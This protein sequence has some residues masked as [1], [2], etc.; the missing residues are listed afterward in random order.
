[1]AR[2]KLILKIVVSLLI[3]QS[4]V[5]LPVIAFAWGTK[6]VGTASMEFLRIGV[7]ARPAAM[8]EAFSAVGDDGNSIF[9]NPAGLGR[10]RSQELSGMHLKWFESFNY[11]TLSYVYPMSH[12]ALGGGL[13]YL[14]REDIE[15]TSAASGAETAERLDTR[16]PSALLRSF[17][18]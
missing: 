6:D 14:S 16:R 10:L 12:G 18:K 1:M 17:E 7:G 15:K 13:L 11:N 9:W 8:G 3:W 2:T 4:A 5:V